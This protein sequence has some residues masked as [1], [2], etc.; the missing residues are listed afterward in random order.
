MQKIQF[1]GSG[2]G[3]E[4]NMFKELKQQEQEKL[5]DHCQSSKF[6]MVKTYLHLKF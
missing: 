6:P 5:Q 2:A 4:P 3:K 1:S